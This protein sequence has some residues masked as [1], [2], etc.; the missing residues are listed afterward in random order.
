MF[1]RIKFLLI[2]VLTFPLLL[3]SSNIDQQVD[4]LL[5]KMTIEEKIE[6]LGGVDRFFIKGIPRLNIPRVK[7]SDGPLGIRAN[8]KSTAFPASIALAATWNSELAF[9]VGQAIGLECRAKD[10]GILLAP[11]IN[12]YRAPMDGRNFEYFGE[13]PLLVSKMAVAY[14]QGVQKNKVV[15]TVKHFVANNQEYDRHWV[16]SNV[17]E[18]TLREIYFP[19]F[20]AAIQKGGAL[21]VMAAYNPLNGTH[22]SENDF[23]LNHILKNEWHFNGLIMSDW[24]AVHSVKAAQA[25]LDLEMP[26]GKFLNKENLLPMLKDS[27]ISDSL[28]ND[29][30]R[31]ILRVCLTMDLFNTRRPRPVIDWDAHHKLALQVAEEGTVLLKNKGDLLPLNPQNVKR[32]VVLGPNAEPTPTSG[33]GS[34]F[35]QPYRKISIL[36]A[37]KERAGKNIQVDFININRFPA[38]ES[39]VQNARFFTSKDLS[40]PGL[41]GIYFNNTRLLAP[42]V[43]RKIATSI[44]F[45]FGGM[46]P[47]FGVRKTEFSIRWR[48]YFKVQESGNY[49][50][51]AESDDGV[52]VYLDGDPI[53]DDWNDHA[54]KRISAEWPLTANKVY[55]IVIEYYNNKGNG[56][57][58][59]GY[60]KI[61][62]TP[63]NQKLQ[64]VK[65]YDVAVVCVGFNPKLEG[66]GHDRPFALPEV[67]NRLIEQVAKLNDQ[68]IVVLNAGGAVKVTP[69][70]KKIKAFIH[71]FYPGQVGGEALAHI[72]F[73]DVNPSARLPFSWEKEWKDAAAFGNYYPVDSTIYKANFKGASKSITYKE[74][75]FLGYRHF[76]KKDIDPQFPFGFGLSYTEFDYDD[77]QISAKKLSKTD[78]LQI[79]LKVRNEG[80]RDGKEVVQLYLQKKIALATP[81]K[82]LKGF[83]KVFLKAGEET[84]VKF[85]LTPEDFAVFNPET[86]RWE[87]QAG[88]Y[89]VLIGSSSRNIR[90]KKKFQIQ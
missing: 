86:K 84:T 26:S 31:R 50:F 22:C 4:S 73:G 7:M 79:S 54:P 12:I 72:L 67:Q 46:P 55:E 53:I 27:L 36:Q 83:K 10:I 52:R 17:D 23:L 51:M 74:G 37:I 38:F 21:A 45:D 11:A 16:S 39:M 20:K 9:K 71:A 82:E 48:G 42:P 13:D 87:V 32:I 35:V 29:K 80:D 5:K 28:I 77:L 75:I 61:D 34:A 57:I 78:T 88:K 63:I 8:G 18:R 65:D 59:F 25:G 19:G 47:A 69:W 62:D 43:H 1:N 70:I 85:A 15:A 14:V 49:V 66:E 90:L 41:K 81:V 2:F 40:T 64:R 76:D 33:G 56:V 60:G 6:L 44:N 3:F 30:V 58:R 68:T 89:Q 24:G